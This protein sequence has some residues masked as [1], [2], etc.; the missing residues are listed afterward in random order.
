MKGG[1]SV[2]SLVS[3]R[4]EG[5]HYSHPEPRTIRRSPAR[6]QCVGP[7]QPFVWEYFQIAGNIVNLSAVIGPLH[8]GPEYPTRPQIDFAFD[9]SPGSRGEPRLDVLRP[10]PRFPH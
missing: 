9:R 1:G 8:Y 4:F 5:D 7:N 3:E 6:K 10:G 2:T